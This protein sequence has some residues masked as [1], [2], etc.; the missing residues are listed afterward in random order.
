MNQRN[1]L[2]WIEEVHNDPVTNISTAFAIEL[3]VPEIKHFGSITIDEE[4]A[5]RESRDWIILEELGFAIKNIKG[6]SLTV[7]AYWTGDNFILRTIFFNDRGLHVGNRGPQ[8]EANCVTVFKN[9]GDIC[10]KELKK[11]G[12]MIKEKAPEFEGYVNIDVVYAEGRLWYYGIRIGIY[13]D[14]MF[15]L[16]V[17]YNVSPEFLLH[18]IEEDLEPKNNF[19]ATLRLY[20]YYYNNGLLQ[21]ILDDCEP[22]AYLRRFDEGAIL[23]GWGENI[24]KA[25]STL[26]NNIPQS[27]KDNLDICYRNDGDRV[28]RSNFY[29]LRNEKL[30]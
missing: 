19:A 24:K 1:G 3:N 12:A 20:T 25:W 2:A 17:L 21:D 26:Y 4:H 29:Q 15:A 7:S 8:I 5:I 28:S 16:A 18:R 23:V 27:V 30:I 9:R 13:Y 14:F 6:I 11:L 22:S 10:I